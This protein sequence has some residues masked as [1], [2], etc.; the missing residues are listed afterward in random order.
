MMCFFVGGTPHSEWWRLEYLFL[1][2]Y[3]NKIIR[4]HFIIPE[5]LDQVINFE[6]CSPV[7]YMTILVPMDCNIGIFS[8]F[9]Y[10]SNFV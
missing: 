9:D 8:V 3:S 7:L 2:R 10:N 1:I 6:F 5:E 4:A